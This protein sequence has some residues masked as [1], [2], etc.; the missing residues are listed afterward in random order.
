MHYVNKGKGPKGG[1]YLKCYRSISSKTC[2]PVAWRY[3]D[4]EESFLFFCRELDLSALARETEK[5]R[6][7]ASAA[8]KLQTAQK[9]LDALIEDRDS[10]FDLLKKVSLEYVAAKL[11]DVEEKIEV[12][13]GIVIAATD[14]YNSTDVDFAVDDEQLFSFINAFRSDTA[15]DNLGKRKNLL[16]KIADSVEYLFLA[17]AGNGPFEQ[18]AHSALLENAE[19][20]DDRRRIRR[21]IDGIADVSKEIDGPFFRVGL[22]GQVNRLVQVSRDDPT[23][24][25]ALINVENGNTS[26]YKDGPMPFRFVKDGYVIDG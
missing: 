9:N 7:K 16:R 22:T 24:L 23:Q 20:E 17:P 6:E 3:D 19:D 21:Y 1:H 5:K 26:A 11:Q 14:L 13:R 8:E 4:F 12:A 2:S 25:V 10:I 15:L 18:I